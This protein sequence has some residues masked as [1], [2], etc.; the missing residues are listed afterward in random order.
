M[1]PGSVAQGLGAQSAEKKQHI[2]DA[3]SVWLRRA[4]RLW[5]ARL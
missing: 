2:D 4:E 5:R 3:L 1:K